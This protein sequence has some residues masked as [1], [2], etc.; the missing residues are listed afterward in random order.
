MNAFLFQ[1]GKDQVIVVAETLHSAEAEFYSF[2]RQN[3]T[4]LNGHWQVV[5]MLNQ[6]DQMIFYL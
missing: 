4:V 6:L 2:I 5:K 1:N 3:P